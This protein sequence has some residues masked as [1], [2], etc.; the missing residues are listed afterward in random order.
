[1]KLSGANLLNKT[2]DCIVNVVES[3]SI[4]STQNSTKYPSIVECL[5]KLENI[6]S[7]TPEDN[8]YV[9]AAILFLKDKFRECFMMLPTDEVRLRFLNL[10]IDM[11]KSTVSIYHG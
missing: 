3:S 11:K 1:M 5:E 9:W 7:V 8:I 6:P 2:L 10:E 4:Q